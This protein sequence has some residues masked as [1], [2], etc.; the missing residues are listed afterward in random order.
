MGTENERVGWKD[1]LTEAVKA[2][3]A[4]AILKEIGVADGARTH[5]A[6]KPL[7]TRI[8]TH[9]RFFQQVEKQVKSG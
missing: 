9:F 6:K 2:Q 7:E 8:K 1:L 5:F 3:A 4:K